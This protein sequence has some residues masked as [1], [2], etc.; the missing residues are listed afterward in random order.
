[1]P[2]KMATATLKLDRQ[3]GGA[4]L[5]ASEDSAGWSKVLEAVARAHERSESTI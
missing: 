4:T 3:N 5:M 1:M 2:E